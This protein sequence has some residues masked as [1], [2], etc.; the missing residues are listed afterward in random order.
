M[1]VGDVITY[2]YNTYN[3]GV[4]NKYLRMSDT[5]SDKQSLVKVVLDPNRF[6]KT[7]GDQFSGVVNVVHDKMFDYNLSFK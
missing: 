5:H 4:N 1:R 6:F 3:S 7:N 2:T